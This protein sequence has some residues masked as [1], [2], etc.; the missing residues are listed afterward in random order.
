MTAPE[1]A[2]DKHLRTWAMH[3]RRLYQEPTPTPPPSSVPP[4]GWRRLWRSFTLPGRDPATIEAEM[5]HYRNQPLR[6]RPAALGVATP[7]PRRRL[8]RRQPSAYLVGVQVPRRSPARPRRRSSRR[9]PR[10]MPTGKKTLGVV[11]VGVWPRRAV[12]VNGGDPDADGFPL[13]VATPSGGRG[14]TW[15]DARLPRSASTPTAGPSASAWP[16]SGHAAHAG[17]APR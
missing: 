3:T 12:A 17:E 7:G 1:A 5:E 2:S 4:P 11:A 13:G 16:C 6:R 15:P 10:S 14:A 8:R 9:R